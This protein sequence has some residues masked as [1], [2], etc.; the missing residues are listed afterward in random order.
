MKKKENNGINRYSIFLYSFALILFEIFIFEI[1]L[2]RKDII[3]YRFSLTLGILLTILLI[4][5]ISVIYVS[6]DLEI[7]KEKIIDNKI[8]L[9]VLIIATF[10]FVYI[11]NVFLNFVLINI[12]TIPFIATIVV[13]YIFGKILEHR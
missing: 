6:K 1:V 10:I 9:I 2:G 4:S 5:M 13:L 11:F 8:L 7:L 3:K 12:P